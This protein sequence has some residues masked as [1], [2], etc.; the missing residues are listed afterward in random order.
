MGTDDGFVGVEGPFA[1]VDYKIGVLAVVELT[2]EPLFLVPMRVR[3]CAEVLRRRV[4]ERRGGASVEV[5]RMFHE[6]V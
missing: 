3:H 4:C 1:A 2:R 5:K 6:R